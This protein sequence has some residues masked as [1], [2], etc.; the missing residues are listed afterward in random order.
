MFFL[1]WT[2]FSF[3]T[4]LDCKQVWLKFLHDSFKT[5]SHSVIRGFLKLNIQMIYGNINLMLSFLLPLFLNTCKEH[6]IFVFFFL[7]GIYFS[8][9]LVYT[10]NVLWDHYSLCSWKV[11]FHYSTHCL[12][13][14]GLEDS[15]HK[16]EVDKARLETELKHERQRVELLQRDLDDSQKVRL[17]GTKC[18]PFLTYSGNCALF[19]NKPLSWLC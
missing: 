9:S 14:E 13:Q 11:N 2:L 12:W 15:V 8:T 17:S 5:F 4:Q 19:C 10:V 3:S 7:R 6:L 1:C 18:Q 16:L